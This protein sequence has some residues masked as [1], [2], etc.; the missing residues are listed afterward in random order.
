MS[1]K[2][3]CRINVFADAG[4]FADDPFIEG[5]FNVGMVS[6][7]HRCGSEHIVHFGKAVG[8]PQFGASCDN[9]DARSSFR[10]RPIAAIEVTVSAPRVCA[11]FRSGR[12][13]RARCQEAILTSSCLFVADEGVDVNG[14]EGF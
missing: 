5:M 11:K 1:L 6:V 10:S 9:R 2:G 13:G 8:I 14:F 12:A 3:I 7:L 4:A